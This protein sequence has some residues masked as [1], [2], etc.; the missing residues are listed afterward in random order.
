MGATHLITILA[1]ALR[2]SDKSKDVLAKEIGDKIMFLC[3]KSCDPTSQHTSESLGNF[4]G[5]IAWRGYPDTS[6]DEVFYWG[7]DLKALSKLSEKEL[8]LAKRFLN[9]ESERRKKV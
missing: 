9:E 7:A 3:D 8:E 5:A 1:D 2:H 6:K 4:M